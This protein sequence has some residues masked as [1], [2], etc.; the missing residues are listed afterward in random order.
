HAAPRRVLVRRP[1]TVA[2]ARQALQHPV[3]LE[4]LDVLRRD[5]DELQAEQR[6]DIGQALVARSSR[7]VDLV[8][9][10]D[11]HLARDHPPA[12]LAETPHNPSELMAEGRGQRAAILA[13]KL[14]AMDG[15][16]LPSALC[17]L[18]ST[19]TPLAPS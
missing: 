16:S 8:L 10:L 9:Q 3:R 13:Q 5:A 19:V 15:R 4:H 12:Q 18:P 6:V 7:P 11:L 1:G 14:R 17:P 2:P